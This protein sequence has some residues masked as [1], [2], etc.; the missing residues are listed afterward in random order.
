MGNSDPSG[1]VG[2]RDGLTIFCKIPTIALCAR[3]AGQSVWW[4]LGQCRSY[5]FPSSNAYQYRPNSLQWRLPSGF[6]IC[7]TSQIAGNSV[8]CSTV[9]SG[10]HKRKARISQSFVVHWSRSFQAWGDNHLGGNPVLLA[11]CAVKAAAEL[12][13]S[14]TECVFFWCAEQNISKTLD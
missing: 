5:R 3:W 2:A 1:W 13:S 6:R 12:A 7:T 8:G 9:C 11:I 14:R 4:H 10:K